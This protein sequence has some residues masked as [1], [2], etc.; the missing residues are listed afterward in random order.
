MAF[1]SV[2]SPAAS[3]AF[4]CVLTFSCISYIIT[5]SEISLRWGKVVVVPEYRVVLTAKVYQELVV[6]AAN[7]DEAKELAWYASESPTLQGGDG[8][9]FC[10]EDWEILECEKK[11]E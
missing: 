11:D 5:T 8:E 6:K 7:Q 10:D 1:R 4:Y 2:S 3:G 9:S